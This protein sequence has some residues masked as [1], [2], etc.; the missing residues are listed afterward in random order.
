MYSIPIIGAM[1]C[2]LEG[3]AIGLVDNIEHN[4]NGVTV[5]V[6]TGDEDD[7]G[8]RDTIP[9]GPGNGALRKLRAVAGEDT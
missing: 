7:P 2:D 1:V 4:P 9:G 8:A 5:Y 6:M 3:N